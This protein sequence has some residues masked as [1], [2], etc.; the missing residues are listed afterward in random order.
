MRL[1]H[2]A[3]A[4]G[5]ASGSASSVGL[6]RWSVSGVLCRVA[7]RFSGAGYQIPGMERG[8]RSPRAVCARAR[9]TASGAEAG[10]VSVLACRCGEYRL[11]RSEALG[12]AVSARADGTEDVL[13]CECCLLGL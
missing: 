2:A 9:A 7:A 1:R 6:A 4:R 3:Q 5:L 11:P 8:L 10:A 13:G 12:G